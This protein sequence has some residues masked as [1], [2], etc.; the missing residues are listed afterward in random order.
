[1]NLIRV[2]IIALLAWLV[3]RMIRG[4]FARPRVG[5][6]PG[7]ERLSTDMVRCDFCGIHIPANEALEQEG[8]YFC[9]EEHREQ[10]GRRQE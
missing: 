3:Y 2:L 5:Q 1:M 4:A 6:R 10:G 7:K 8:R 9:S